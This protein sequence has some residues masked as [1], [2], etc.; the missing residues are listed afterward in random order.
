MSRKRKLWVVIIVVLVLLALVAGVVVWEVRD[1]NRRF[2]V[3]APY[4][5]A[6]SQYLDDTGRLPPSLDDLE[7]HYNAYE[8]RIIELPVPV[9]C[10]PRILFF[11]VQASD[12]RFYLVMA[13][14]KTD[15]VLQMTRFMIYVNPHSRSVKIE[16]VWRW[17]VEH[18]IQVGYLD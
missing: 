4:A 16:A 11:P 12:D 14:P 6:L 3:Y 18:G 17:E 9:D 5:N 15:R 13:E 7:R 8:Y 1:A 2:F 10:Y